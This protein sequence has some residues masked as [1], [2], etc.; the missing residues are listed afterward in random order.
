MR[1]NRT[2]KKLA[3]ALS[4]ENLKRRCNGNLMCVYIYV[5][6]GLDTKQCTRMSPV[7]VAI[8]GFLMSVNASTRPPYRS[9]KNIAKPQVVLRNSTLSRAKVTHKLCNFASA[10]RWAVS[11]HAS[12][13]AERS[14]DTQLSLEYED[15]AGHRTPL[16]ASKL[17]NTEASGRVC[18]Q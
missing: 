16:E 14:R 8:S 2:E 13:P 17:G 5:R 11:K 6:H 1:N 9:M 12:E 10:R 15:A 4:L 7:K 3:R 18:V